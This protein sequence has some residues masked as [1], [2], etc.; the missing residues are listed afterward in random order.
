M[1]PLYLLKAF[2]KGVK[3]ISAVFLLM[4]DDYF[5]LSGSPPS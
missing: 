5:G 1:G 4:M 3:V 2:P